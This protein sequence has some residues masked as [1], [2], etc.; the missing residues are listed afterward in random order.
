MVHQIDQL[1]QIV[2]VG[3]YKKTPLGEVQQNAAFR[4]LKFDQLS[5]LESY[6]HLR[7]VRQEDK[8]DLA[9]REE[10]ICTHDFLDDASLEKPSQGWTIRRDEI[11]PSVV[12]LRSRV[13]PGFCAYARAN[14]RIFGGLYIGDGLKNL[15]LPF[16]I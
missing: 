2:P 1:C 12:V 10:D 9:A 16:M 8:I 14:C 6:M 4:G 7:P 5:Q 3:S 13:Y 15:T 11:N